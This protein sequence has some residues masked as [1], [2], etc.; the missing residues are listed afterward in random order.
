[1]PCLLI[2]PNP[3]TGP[4]KRARTLQQ[5]LHQKQTLP[6][7]GQ[8]SRMIVLLH[9]RNGRKEDLIP[10]AERFVAAGYRC[11]LPDLPAHGD[12]PLNTMSF[13]SSHFE[14]QLPRLIVNDIRQHFNLPNQPTSLWGLSMGGAFA[15][16]AAKESPHYWQSLIIVSSFD[17]LD[18]LLHDIAYYQIN[19]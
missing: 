8:A 2:E 1:M 11:V 12:S 9:G 14:S 17:R 4:A 3:A 6:P 16:S 13:G 15:L 5:Q 10:V 18:T 19:D 7:Y